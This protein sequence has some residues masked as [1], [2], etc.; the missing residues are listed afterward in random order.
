VEFPFPLLVCDIGGTNARF[1]ALHS[2][3]SMLEVGP[4]LATKDFPSF[5]AALAAVMPRLPAKPRSLIVCVA[6]PVAGRKVTMTNADWTIDAVAV[7][8]EFGLAQGLLLNDFEAQALSLPIVQPDWVQPIG[9]SIGPGPGPRLVMGLGTGLGTAALVTVEGRHLA[10]ATE[11]GH[12]D[13]A[14]IGA[15]DEAI[16]RHIDRTPLGRVTAEIVLS[17]PGLIRLHRARCLAEGEATPAFDEIALVEHAR[18]APGGRE[19]QTLAAIWLLLARFAGDLAL[20]F[21]AKGGITF[22]GGVLPRIL[23]FLDEDAFRAQ[24]EAK[25]PYAALMKEIATEIVI[26][27]DIVLHGLAAIARAPQSY[28]IDFSARAWR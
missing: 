11:A 19:A 24:F 8:A 12:M 3:E 1:A 4:H 13:F 7:A 6:G 16:W 18:A 17:G 22:S 26:A 9:R 20:A 2:P 28:A 14:P 5:E 21:L 23:P 25:A 15:Q 27:E 10:L